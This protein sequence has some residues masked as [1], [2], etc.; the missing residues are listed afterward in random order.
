[1]RIDLLPASKLH[2]FLPAKALFCDQAAGSADEPEVISPLSRLMKT[3][4]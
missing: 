4:G 2:L 1:M 3:L